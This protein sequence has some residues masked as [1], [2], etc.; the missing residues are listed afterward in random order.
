MLL[1]SRVFF[2]SKSVQRV[3]PLCIWVL[4]IQMTQHFK[5]IFEEKKILGTKTYWMDC[6][7]ML[8]A[9]TKVSS[10][11][12]WGQAAVWLRTAA[13]ITSYGFGQGP[14]LWTFLWGSSGKHD[15]WASVGNSKTWTRL[16]EERVN[17]HPLQACAV[18][19][20]RVCWCVSNKSDVHGSTLHRAEGSSW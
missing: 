7:S 6:I 18:K 1:L 5:Y 20:I 17:W 3:V 9:L 15:S 19:V 8:S 10:E 12:F 2:T 11:V 16:M 14:Y 13:I 4:I